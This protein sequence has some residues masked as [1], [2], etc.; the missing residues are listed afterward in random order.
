MTSD[1]R[2]AIA[3]ANGMHSQ[4]HSSLEVLKKTGSFKR[5]SAVVFPQALGPDFVEA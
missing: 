4:S 1:L 2:N 5:A 3:L